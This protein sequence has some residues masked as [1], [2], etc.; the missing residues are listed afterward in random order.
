MRKWTENELTSPKKYTPLHSTTPPTYNQKYFDLPQEPKIPKFQLLPLTLAGGAH[1]GPTGAIIGNHILNI[2]LKHIIDLE[3]CSARVYDGASATV[4]KSKGASAVIK[5]Q[6][7]Q[8]EFVHCRGHCINLAVV[9][10]CKNEVIRGFMADLTSFCFFFAISSKRQ[11]YFEKFIDFH[12]ELF[13][14]S[15]TNRTHIIGIS[16]TRW[17]ERHTAYD[18][19]FMLYKFVDSA[20]ESIVD[21]KL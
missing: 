1:Y 21:I 3:H 11:Q 4:S 17:V 12:K 13:K 20:F 15:E 16:K 9:F 19:Y 6:Q 5:S 8:A 7:P 2:L 14:V 18:N 10:A